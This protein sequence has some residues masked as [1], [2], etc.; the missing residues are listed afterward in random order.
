MPLLSLARCIQHERGVRAGKVGPLGKA[1]NRVEFAMTG[2][3]STPWPAFDTDAGR[4]QHAFGFMNP[5]FSDCTLRVYCSSKAMF[6]PLSLLGVLPSEGRTACRTE[7]RG[8]YGYSC[9]YGYFALDSLMR[10]TA[11]PGPVQESQGQ[12]IPVS[13][14]ST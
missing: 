13:P 8:R 7:F 3:P 12:C 9:S 6:P 2:L 1:S 5:D 10:R 14:S 4:C 11:G